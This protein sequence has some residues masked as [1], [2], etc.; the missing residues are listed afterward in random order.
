MF[1]EYHLSARRGHETNFNFNETVANLNVG[2]VERMTDLF[3]TSL[4]YL[5]FDFLYKNFAIFHFQVGW[6]SWIGLFLATDLMWYWYHRFGHTMNIFWSVHVVHHQSEDFNYTVSARITIFQAMARCIFWSV[7]PIAGFP[8]GMISLFLIIHGM[9]PFF[10]HTKL[11]RDLGWLEYL[12][13]TPS[14]HRV[15]HATNPQYLDKNYGDILIIWD[16]MFG[17]FTKEN[18][19]PVYGLTKPLKSYSFLWQHFHYMLEMFISFKTSPTFKGKF[20]I[21]FGKPDSVDPRAREL[22]ERKFSYRAKQVSLNPNCA[23][24]IRWQTAGLMIILFFVLLFEYYLTGIQLAAFLAFF[25]TSVIS[26]GAVLEQK[27]W[28]FHLE[29][30]RVMLMVILLWLLLPIPMLG[31]CLLIA[32]VLFGIYYK[33]LEAKY[34]HSLLRMT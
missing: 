24:Y 15:H 7:L 16:K 25:I 13:V 11:I 19:E 6:L 5:L 18:E 4:F 31:W 21:L 8:P 26:T 33:K 12:L 27:R 17:T 2:I 32:T 30:T 20:N 29:A 14:H 10:I 9:Y 28:L 3:T 23:G 1:I 34:S 22:L